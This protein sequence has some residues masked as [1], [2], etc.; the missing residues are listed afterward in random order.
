[1]ERS[2]PSVRNGI[3]RVADGSAG[4]GSVEGPD[5]IASKTEG[6]HIDQVD[7]A[8]SSGR[9]MPTENGLFAPGVSH[10]AEPVRI[11]RC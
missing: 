11:T 7:L 1:M 10:E 4:T 6:D 8:T 2:A 3:D 5:R 9:L